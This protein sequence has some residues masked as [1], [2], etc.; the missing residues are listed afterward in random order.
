M[1]NLKKSGEAKK[2]KGPVQYR[3]GGGGGKRGVRRAWPPQSLVMTWRPPSA[4]GA[5]NQDL[6]PTPQT[7]RPR[8][9]NEDLYENLNTGEN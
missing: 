6:R 9:T 4:G 1:A 7:G 8:R 3:R 5:K 2:A